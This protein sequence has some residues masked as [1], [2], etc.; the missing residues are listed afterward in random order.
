MLNK[1]V[2]WP[3][4]FIAVFLILA[5]Q[6]LARAAGNENVGKALKELM[7]GP[8]VEM[9]SQFANAHYESIKTF[10]GS[11]SFKPVWSRDSGPKGKAKALLAE[12]RTSKAHG[13]SPQ[14]YGYATLL[15]L[16]KSKVPEDLARMDLLITGALVEFSH[17]LLNGRLTNDT[18]NRVNRVQPV[19]LQPAQLV[20]QAAAAG[21]LSVMLG[22][23]VGD[24]RRYIRLVSKMVDYNRVVASGRWPKKPIPKDID[25]GARSDHMRSVRLMLVLTGDLQ[26]QEMKSNAS[27]DRKLSD[28]LARYQRRH[29]VEDN[30]ELD[31]KTIELLNRPLA[32]RV[33]L[34]KVNLE[35]RRWQN[36]K[37]EGN[38]LYLNLVDGQLKLLVKDKTAAQISLSKDGDALETPTFYG[39]VVSVERAGSKSSPKIRLTFVQDKLSADE[40]ERSGE[41]LLN[42]EGG[43]ARTFLQKA[44][45]QSD[46]A[47]FNKISIG[48]QMKLSNPVDL[49]VTYLTVWATRDGRIQFR[50]DVE[51]RDAV[52]MKRLGL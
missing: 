38:L 43:A 33:K 40:A 35:R 10:Y 12:L 31:A 52:V 11:R 8:P 51:G 32:D 13:L 3:R 28:A 9:G 6:T 19:Q 45:D 27:V 44:L 39:K 30:G 37:A 1:Y 24:D 23:I 21:N 34:A 26:F 46:Q 20:E 7:S 36:R 18:K 2:I 41:F 5:A 29:G 47:S 16:M 17:D 4:V 22:G 48:K 42:D 14:F 50:A 15:E 25:P 49:F